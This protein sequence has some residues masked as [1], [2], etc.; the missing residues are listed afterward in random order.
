MGAIPGLGGSWGCLI[1]FALA[2]HGEPAV[3]ADPVE[4]QAGQRGVFTVERTVERG[5]ARS[6][7]TAAERR[8]EFFSDPAGQGIQFFREFSR[9]TIHLRFRGLFEFRITF[10][11]ECG[12]GAADFIDVIR[13]GQIRQRKFQVFDHISNPFRLE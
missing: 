11:S 1:M 12:G 9:K 8:S 10:Q 7:G 2:D 5:G 6:V 13:P 3:L 4:S